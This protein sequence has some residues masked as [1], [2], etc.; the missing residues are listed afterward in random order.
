MNRRQIEAVSAQVA[1]EKMRQKGFLLKAEN[2][3][4][5]VSFQISFFP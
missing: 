2:K 1:L 4:L 5:K 3:R